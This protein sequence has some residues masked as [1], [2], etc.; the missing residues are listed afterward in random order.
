MRLLTAH[1]PYGTDLGRL[2]ATCPADKHGTYTAYA[3]GCR[4]PHAR[5][6]E[7]LYRKRRRFGVQPAG[8]VDACGTRR[9]IEA[10]HAIGHTG[11]DIAAKMG[12]PYDAAWLRKVRSRN[13]SVTIRSHHAVKAAYA[14]LASVP[15]SSAVTRRR[16]AASGFPTPGQWGADIDDPKAVPDLGE[17]DL[18]DPADL[19][20]VD[21]QVVERALAGE[22]VFLTDVELVVALRMGTARGGSVSAVS[23]LLGLNH[24]AAKRLLA[25]E[26]TPS[27]AR[28]SL[29]AAELCR[30]PNVQAGALAARLGVRVSA[31]A[32][33]RDRLRSRLSL[34]S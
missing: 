21:E 25:G 29:I 19:S 17:P 32:G 34:A 20:V 33:V 26:S 5:E 8:L 2:D 14:T 16:A 22:R 18:L 30:D 3:R 13:S 23:A 27:R 12:P 24:V 4:C 31:V 7:R 6:A 11:A 10:L 1:V 28:W 15:G 9:R